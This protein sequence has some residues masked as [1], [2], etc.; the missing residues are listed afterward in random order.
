MVVT[1]FSGFFLYSVHAD[2]DKTALNAAYAEVNTINTTQTNSPIGDPYYQTASFDA[3]T[4][5]IDALGGLAAIQA[6]IDDALATQIDVDNLTVDINTAIG[7]LILNDTYYVTL[8]NFS[9]A[10]SIDLSPYTTTSQTTYNLELDRIEVILNN[11]TAGDSVISGLNTDIDNAD[12]LLVLRGDKTTLNSLITQIDTIYITDGTTYI[13][14][15]FTNFQ[16]AYD[17]IDTT[18]QTDIGMTLQQLVDNIDATVDDV[19]AGENRLNEILSLLVARPDKTTLISDYNTA[20]QVDGSIYTTSSFAQFTAGLASINALINNVEATQTEVDQAILDV[21]TLYNVLIEKGDA[22]TLTA[23]YNIAIA[24][25]LSGY[26]PN[27]VSDYLDELE[28]IETIML[29]ADSSQT[30]M[31]Q[32]VIDL[33]LAA[34]LL[35]L[36]ADRSE[37]SALNTLVII[38]YYEERTKYTESSYLAF[39]AAVDA[40]GSYMYVNSIVNND[41]IDQVTVDTLSQTLEVALDTLVPLV[42]NSALLIL[43][44][45]LKQSD[46]SDYTTDS[47][48]A[49]LTELERLYEIITGKELNDLAAA[50]VV[51]DMTE[52][53]NLLVLLPDFTE[54]QELYDSTTIYREEDYSISSYGSFE[55]AKLNA[56]NVIHDGNATEEMVE[57]AILWL[58]TSIDELN[59]ELEKVYINVDQT[60]DVNQ[61]ITLGRASISDYSV[62]DSTVLTI[63][64]NGIVTGLSYGETTVSV[65]L[66]NGYTEIIQIYVKAK[67]STT[68]I[69]LTIT[70]PVASIGLGAAIVYVK[71]E[72]WIL[73]A[74]K[75]V[76]LFK[77][78]P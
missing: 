31:D 53:D 44:Y 36:Q 40:Y 41:N 50:Q 2:A 14:S 16:T 9:Q 43:Y 10:N 77:K 11:P 52:A 68:V 39:Q 46:L 37:L 38:A 12:N 34:D 15:T 21:A 1:M 17:N 59:L 64:S 35:V 48:N 22:T 62:A 70:T 8:A 67:L 55:T 74:K 51:T 30:D 7:G 54:L 18:L 5:A 25:D 75:I 32:A 57:D 71:K 56:N 27:S 26:T 33:T 3:F 6:V 42:D 20:T 4:A 45:E 69:V 72:T 76:G 61:Y 73:I 49:Y 47:K 58:Q 60:L 19:S 63:D 78:K 13:P 28:R 65:T 23:A 66:D 24:I 29:S